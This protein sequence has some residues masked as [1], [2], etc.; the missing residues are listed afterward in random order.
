[1]LV[2]VALLVG[3]A[4]SSRAQP[5]GGSASQSPS[6]FSPP[7]NQAIPTGTAVPIVETAVATP[8]RRETPLATPSSDEAQSIDLAKQDLA[9]RKGI[10]TDRISVVTVT[11]VQWPTSALGCPQPGTM[12][13]QI[14]TPG[15]RILLEA[16]GVTYEYHTDQGERAVYCAKP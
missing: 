9:K 14:V 5:S 6:S 2:G 15:Y 16:D 11:A 7:P 12:Y 8:A 3:C 4:G 13:S 1:M 10:A